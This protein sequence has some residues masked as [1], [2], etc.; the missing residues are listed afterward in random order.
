M[1]IVLNFLKTSEYT[2]YRVSSD[3]S[4]EMVNMNI[5]PYRVIN[6]LFN[7]HSDP[8]INVLDERTVIVVLASSSAQQ[9]CI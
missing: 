6:I 4:V 2:F 9:L 3:P 7:K 5:S 8:A 1:F